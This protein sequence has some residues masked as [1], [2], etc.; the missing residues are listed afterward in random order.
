MPT[1]AEPLP[2]NVEQ[3]Q[4][5][6]L[7]ERQSNTEKDDQILSLRQ[8]NQFLLEQF[9]LAQHKQFGQSHESADQLGL[10]NEVEQV[11]DDMAAEVSV[12]TINAGPFSR[13]FAGLRRP[14]LDACRR[15]RSLADG[16]PV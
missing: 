14:V 5:L 3:L 12:I 9:R 6:L 2:D 7:A 10:F 8:E 11:A 13:L 1:A 16:E 4:A 15:V